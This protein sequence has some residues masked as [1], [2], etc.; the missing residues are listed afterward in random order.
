M[1]VFDVLLN[2]KVDSVLLCEKTVGEVL[3]VVFGAT[4]ASAI[5]VMISLDVEL[6]D[7]K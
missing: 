3:L 6:V 4:V 2:N 5:V 1:V 7:T